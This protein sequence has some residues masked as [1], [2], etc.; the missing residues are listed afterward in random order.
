MIT[1][2][3]YGRAFFQAGWNFFG[4]LYIRELDQ[5]LNCFLFASVGIQF[6]IIIRLQE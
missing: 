3:P 1:N 2:T 5:L 4:D 6:R